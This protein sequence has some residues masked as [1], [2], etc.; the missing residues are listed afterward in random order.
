MSVWKKKE[1]RTTPVRHGI[2]IGQRG[3]GRASIEFQPI[4]ESA[5]QHS[6]RSLTLNDDDGPVGG[7]LG[8]PSWD[9]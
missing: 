1:V 6:N 8:R 7:S 5:P 3:L 9:W 2:F 4:K